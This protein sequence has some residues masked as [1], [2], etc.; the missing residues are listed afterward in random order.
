MRPFTER[1]NSSQL[2]L[3]LSVKF[4]VS[5]CLITDLL[6]FTINP[7]KNLQ[8]RLFKL[9]YVSRSVIA[10]CLE[11]LHN[12]NVSFTLKSPAFLK[13]RIFCNVMLLLLLSRLVDRHD[14][15]IVQSMTNDSHNSDLW[16]KVCVNESLTKM[17]TTR[18]GTLQVTGNTCIR[19]LDFDILYCDFDKELMVIRFI[20]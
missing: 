1:Q 10:C 18:R 9:Y 7:E 8:I 3:F 14:L 5:N 12:Y 20:S 17:F 15:N 19:L 16:E 11:I 2:K 6:Y 4:D 13:G